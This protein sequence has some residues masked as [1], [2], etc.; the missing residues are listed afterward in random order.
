MSKSFCLSTEKNSEGALLVFLKVSGVSESFWHC[1]F[2]GRKISVNIR[3]CITKKSCRIKNSLGGPFGVSERFRCQK[4]LC[5]RSLTGGTDSGDFWVVYNTTHV[6]KSFP[7]FLVCVIMT[8]V[9][10]LCY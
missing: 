5:V 6:Q 1:P 10:C 4:I 9:P 7:V 2:V 8:G 3:G